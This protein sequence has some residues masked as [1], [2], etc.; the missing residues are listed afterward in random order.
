MARQKETPKPLFAVKHDFYASLDRMAHEAIMMV[1]TAEQLLD[2][3]QVKEPGKKILKERVE[4][5]RA[6]LTADD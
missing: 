4:A 2:L 5:F 3:D 6:A 1:Q